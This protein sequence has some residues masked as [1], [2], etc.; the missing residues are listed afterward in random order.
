MFPIVFIHL[1]QCPKEEMLFLEFEFHPLILTRLKVYSNSI[2]REFS[3]RL[4]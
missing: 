2:E 3:P 4:S 1:L